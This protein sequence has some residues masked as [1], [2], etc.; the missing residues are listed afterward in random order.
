MEF[1]SF[2][3]DMIFF[4][5]AVISMSWR[6]SQ[7]FRFQFFTRHAT[8]FAKEVGDFGMVEA[9]GPIERCFAVKRT[10]L[11]LNPHIHIRTLGEK[12]F[13]DVF[14]TSMSRI[15]QRSPHYRTSFRIHIDTMSQEIF[16]CFNISAVSSAINRP[17]FAA[18]FA[19]ESGSFTVIRPG[20]LIQCCL[21]IIIPG[22][23]FRALC[24]K[25]VDDFLVTCV[26]VGSEIFS[27]FSKPSNHRPPC[28]SMQRSIT[29][30]IALHV[31]LR[32]FDNQ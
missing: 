4:S 26:R 15:M 13:D 30:P 25:Q 8:V 5:V 31:H 14:A 32:S 22:I 3:I 23:D 12:Q 19:E 17:V 18:V 27:L 9:V 11:N 24:D 6:V 7:V 10:A 28:C 21:A 16:Y 1:P 29:R 20:G 2:E